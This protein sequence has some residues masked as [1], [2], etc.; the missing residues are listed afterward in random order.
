V[1]PG[2]FLAAIVIFSPVF[3]F[4]PGLAALFLIEKVPNPVITT[5]SPLFSESRMPF[6]KAP[7]A[8]LEALRVRFPFLETN[9]TRSFFVKIITSPCP[10]LKCSV[11]RERI[12]LK[13]R[14]VN[15]GGSYLLT[16]ILTIQAK[17]KDVKR[18]IMKRIRWR[19]RG[20]RGWR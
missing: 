13:S 18:I 4:L 10:P 19:R 17:P 20:T 3:G 12:V 5:F 2:A 11:R 16:N 15:L 9:S 8:S 6:K 7:T 14:T 1:N